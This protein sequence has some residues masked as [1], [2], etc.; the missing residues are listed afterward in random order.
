MKESEFC[1]H[2]RRRLNTVLT[3]VLAL[4]ETCPDTD[5]NNFCILNIITLFTPL[6]FAKCIMCKVCIIVAE[7][8]GVQRLYNLPKSHNTRN[9]TLNPGLSLSTSGALLPMPQFRVKGIILW[10]CLRCY[11]F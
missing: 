1:S 4:S 6:V 3:G 8:T 9:R 10:P 5:F 11:R 2:L 7:E